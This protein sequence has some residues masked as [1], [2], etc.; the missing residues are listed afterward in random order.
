MR[1]RLDMSCVD[2]QRD[3]LEVLVKAALLHKTT[4]DWEKMRGTREKLKA[5]TR[6]IKRRG[7]PLLDLK[8]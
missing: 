1:F 4:M 8:E 5:K 2:K 6:Q 7:Q 3:V